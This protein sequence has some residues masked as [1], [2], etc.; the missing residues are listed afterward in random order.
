M[1]EIDKKHA[2]RKSGLFAKS[3][4]ACSEKLH[5]PYRLYRKQRH[6]AAVV[7]FA[8]IA[9]IFIMLI[10]GMIEYGRMVMVQQV[11]T[12]SAR[13]GARRAVLDGAAT[14]EVED[15]V[16][17][18]LASSQI[19]GANVTVTPNPPTTA[20]FGEPVTVTVTIG[21]E[22]V[23]WLPGSMFLGDAEMQA[24]SVMRRETVQ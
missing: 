7:E 13:E 11:L 14:S 23:S 22:D 8:I 24:S 2:I 6:G 1:S 9:P 10:F 16:E 17:N 5:K 18:Y 20:G 19:N 21:F 12:N 15:V 4:R 3:L